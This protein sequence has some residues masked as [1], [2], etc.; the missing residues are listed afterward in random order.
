MLQSCFTIKCSYTEW[1]EE[2]KDV[3]KKKEGNITSFVWFIEG[4]VKV[5]Y[6]WVNH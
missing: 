5:N 6:V 3:N 1:E 4:I 2:E